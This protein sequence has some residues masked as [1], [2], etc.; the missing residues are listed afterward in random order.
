MTIE[1]QPSTLKDV[2]NSP[3]G[4]KRL[5]NRT[6]E[7]KCMDCNGL[8]EEGHILVLYA[9]AFQHNPNHRVVLEEEACRMGLVI[10]SE[11]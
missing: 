8:Y 9:L 1:Y 6:G 11:R 5:K 3:Y 2:I 10:L 7:V 4:K